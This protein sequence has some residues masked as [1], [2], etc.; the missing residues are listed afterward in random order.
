LQCQKRA[1]LLSRSH[2]FPTRLALQS[3]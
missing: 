3:H 1:P 2:P